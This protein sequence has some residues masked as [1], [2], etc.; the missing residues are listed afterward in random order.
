MLDVVT[1]D[2]QSAVGTFLFPIE[3]DGV[4]IDQGGQVVL[5]APSSLNPGSVFVQATV[6]VNGQAVPLSAQ[7]ASW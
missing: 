7:I 5:T 1:L 2:P 3:V 6:T 4:S